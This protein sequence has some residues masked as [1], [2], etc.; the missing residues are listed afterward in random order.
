[1]GEGS[2]DRPDT[3][4]SGS[5]GR[6]SVLESRRMGWLAPVAIGLLS[7]S[8]N[9][10]GNARIGLWDRDEPR[11]AVA[12]REMRARGDWIFPTFNG[13]PRYH[14]PILIYWLMGLATA[15][16][17]DNPFGVRL[18]SALAGA[19][20]CLMVWGMGRRMFGA[21]A[22]FLAGLMLAVSPINVAES[23]LATTDA[24]MA[25]FIVCT[26]ACLLELAIRPSRKVAAGFWACLS[27]AC[28]T[29][30]PI[31]PIL[32]LIALA[33]A[34]WWG[35]PVPVVWKR[36]YPRWGLAAFLAVALPWYVAIAI[37]SRG[38]YL[39]FAF[40][41]Q[42]LSRL[43][44]GMEQHGGFPGYYLALAVLAFF[45]WSALVPAAVWG[46]WQRRRTR[47]ELRFL[48]G[49]IIGPWLFLECL[50][51]RMV[52]YI[53]PAFPACALLVAWMIDSIE[54]EDVTLRRWPLGRLGLNLLGGVGITGTVGLLAITPALSSP[55]RLPLVLLAVLTGSATMLAMLWLHQGATRKAAVGLGAVFGV[56]FL[57]VGGWLIPAAE[58]YRTSSKVGRRLAE[59]VE[60]TGIQPALLNYK[61]PGVI[62]AVGKPVATPR[63]RQEFDDLLDQ[64]KVL[65]TVV[66]PKERA[67]YRDRYRLEITPLES[68]D[69]LSLTKGKAPTLDFVLVKRAAPAQREV[70]STARSGAL[71]QSLIK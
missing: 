54:A 61:E 17:G 2:L 11:F 41:T 21:R 42:I 28:L 36:L 63:N 23:K 16:A 62:Y 65:L 47:P 5:A 49:W 10:A 22:G 70:E 56:F 67:D 13:E 25:F 30:G 44:G 53:L 50:P 14:K 9:L 15:L 6:G 69:G 55:V 19:G 40:H 20:T 33:M 64:K 60:K 1:M 4:S 7:L 18:V 12:V 39:H 48:L 35:W 37:A 68:L 71:E 59:L 58:P 26:Q 45:P 57:I 29:K 31:G 51:T 3:V 66:T 8:I 24:T 34:W 27:L 46:A 43:T 38:A 32:L 52:H